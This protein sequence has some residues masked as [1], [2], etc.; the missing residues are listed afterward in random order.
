MPPEKILA[1]YR[2]DL[3]S[4]TPGERWRLAG[5]AG[6]IFTPLFAVFLAWLFYGPGLRELF[7]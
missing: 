6:L 7:R 1:Q 4:L 5:Y 2:A 3:R